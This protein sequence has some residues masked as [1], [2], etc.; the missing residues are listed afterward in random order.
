MRRLLDDIGMGGAMVG[1]N[2]RA[3]IDALHS[4]EAEQND[5]EDRR[6]L[7]AGVPSWVLILV[8]GVFFIWI[9]FFVGW[10]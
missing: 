1:S 2:Q 10:Q 3:E 8:F 7:L 6:G 5:G 9:V 4:Y